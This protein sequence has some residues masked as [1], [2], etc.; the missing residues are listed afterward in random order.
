[1]ATKDYYK[2]LQVDPS[3][4][5]EIIAAAYKRLALKYH[6]DTNKEAD[7]NLKMQEINAAYQI[8]SDAPKRAEYD[9]LRRDERAHPKS[10]TSKQEP[11]DRK[12]I[13]QSDFFVTSPYWIEDITPQYRR[14]IRNGY[15]HIAVSRG[16]R[17]FNYIPFYLRDFR[18]YIDI[19]IA[20]T[21][22]ALGAFCGVMFRASANNQGYTNCYDLYIDS[23]GN[24]AL[25]L[26]Q[27]GEEIRFLANWDKSPYIYGD[28][29]LVS[30][31]WKE[32]KK[33]DGW[34]FTNRFMIE[35]KG[36]T[37]MVGANKKILSKLDDN[38]WTG[39][40]IGVYVVLDEEILEGKY[41]EARFR[42]FR[43][44]SLES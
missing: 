20:E 41:A 22:S 15:Y 23:S 9:L 7:S 32:Y 28:H 35:A 27:N 24:A 25:V 3:A 34:R 26:I 38:T 19:Q 29:T 40:Y 42:N 36:Q 10:Q 1:M 11:S 13:H 16:G 18:L 37:L 31:D 33:E 21:S 30:M 8:L 12:L 17:V 5:P 44:Y 43:L 39:G 4:E 6:P 2:I 14:F